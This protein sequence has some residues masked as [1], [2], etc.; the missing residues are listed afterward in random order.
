MAEVRRALLERV[1]RVLRDLFVDDSLAVTEDTKLVDI[2]EWD[3]MLHVT[4]VMA[5][6]REFGIRLNAEETDKA[7]AVR[8][9]VDLLEIKLGT[10]NEFPGRL[11]GSGSSVR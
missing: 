11:N 5:L 8:P 10:G 2:P 9:I 7:V 6:E 4:L 3:S 1:R